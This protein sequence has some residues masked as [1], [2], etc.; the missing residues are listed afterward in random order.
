MAIQLKIIGK[1]EMKSSQWSGGTTTEM[2]IGPPG[3]SYA[4]R[5]F[6]VRVSSARVE[7]ESSQFTALPGIDRHLMVLEGALQVQHLGHHEKYLR[8]FETDSFS[9]DWETHSIGQ[10]L[11]FNLM[12]KRGLKGGLQ[13]ISLSGDTT[14]TIEMESRKLILLYS[15]AGSFNLSVGGDTLR[16]NSGDAG[17]VEITEMDNI[18]VGLEKTSIKIGAAL[19]AATVIAAWVNQ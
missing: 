17:L 9:G 7:L 8:P 4:E 12:V 19:D 2:Y 14:H 15:Y 18:T 10:V 1:D 13:A 5:N 11:D 6:D 3:A 16:V